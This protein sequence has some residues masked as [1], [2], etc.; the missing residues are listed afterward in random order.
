MQVLQSDVL[1]R[2]RLQPL[3]IGDLHATELGLPDVNGR[4]A[5]AVTAAHLRRLLARLLLTQDPDNPLFAGP[6]SPHRHALLLRRGIYFHLEETSGAGQMPSSDSKPG[7][8]TLSDCR[9]IVTCSQATI[10]VVKIGF[11]APRY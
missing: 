3:G 5:D 8:Q 11:D 10:V 6:L 9:Q 2:Q 7:Y 4:W 1:L